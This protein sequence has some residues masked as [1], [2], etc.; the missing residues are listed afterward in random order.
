MVFKVHPPNCGCIWMYHVISY[1]GWPTPHGYHYNSLNIHK[2][3]R[4]L[5]KSHPLRYD[6]CFTTPW[7]QTWLARRYL[8]G[9][10]R[11]LLWPRGALMLLGLSLIMEWI[12]PI[13]S[14]ST[15]KY[16][17]DRIWGDTIFRPHHFGIGGDTPYITI[18]VHL[19]SRHVDADGSRSLAPS[20]SSPVAPCSARTPRTTRCWKMGENEM[21]N[22]GMFKGWTVISLKKNLDMMIWYI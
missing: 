12:I 10:W 11:P 2:I 19:F 6:S 18:W 4:H 1:V 15:S 16:L 5:H 9:S 3:S 8:P 7:L 13:H 21:S 20:P 22:V 17:F 14:R